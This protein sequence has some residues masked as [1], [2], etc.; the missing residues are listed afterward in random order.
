MAANNLCLSKIVHAVP[1]HQ[2]HLVKRAIYAKQAW[3]SLRSVYQ[4]RNSLWASTLE[5]DII[6][7]RCQP[8]MKITCWLN[9]MQRLYNTLCGT[10]PDCM[11]DHFFAFAILNNMPQDG[12]WHDF[13]SGL[14]NKVRDY[15][16]HGTPVSSI[17]FI[18]SIRE[19]FWFRHGDDLQNNAL[20]FS[21]RSE[22]DRHGVKHDRAAAQDTT[23]LPTNKCI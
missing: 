5:S 10:D 3:E 22:V 21:A 18:T 11:T 1:T 8:S 9:D 15:D 2:L 17:D 16:N 19:E 4:P 6:T 13:L 20:V 12:T 14:R 7:Y 23:Q